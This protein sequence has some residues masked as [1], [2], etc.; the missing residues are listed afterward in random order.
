MGIAD[1]FAVPMALT[2]LR[3][4]TADLHRTVE[5]QVPLMSK[6]F[7]RGQYMAWLQLMHPFYSAIDR[8]LLGAHQT[9]PI[10]WTYLPRAPLIEQ[11][12]TWLNASP[13]DI[14]VELPRQLLRLESTHHRLGVLYVVEGSALGGQVLLKA[15]A[16]SVGVTAEQG[17]RFLAP[18]GP[19]PKSHWAGFIKC[20]RPFDEKPTAV[21]AIVEGAQTTFAALSDW[22]NIPSKP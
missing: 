12:L 3:K 6:D 15:L 2:A 11:D 13:K 7:D 20:L 22:M 10:S 8:I 14:C 19:D 17:A 16:R 5:R 21:A 9:E 4:A 18:H 1:S